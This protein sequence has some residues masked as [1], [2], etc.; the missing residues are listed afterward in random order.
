[1]EKEEHVTYFLHSAIDFLYTSTTKNST[2]LISSHSLH[3]K[4]PS[5]HTVD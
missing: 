5:N 4:V 1:M 3:H 2:K